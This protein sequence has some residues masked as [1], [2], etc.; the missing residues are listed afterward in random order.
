MNLIIIYLL[1]CYAIMAI[2]IAS[3][4]GKD[5]QRLSNRR[6]WTIEY[7]NRIMLMLSPIIIT[8]IFVEVWA[9][10]NSFFIEDFNSY[11]TPKMIATYIQNSTEKRGLR[12]RFYGKLYGR[13]RQNIRRG[14]CYLP[15]KK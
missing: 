14:Y 2:Y 15:R 6:N 12:K 9:C 3:T 10:I 13:E 4:N 7:V 5:A 1:S 11:N 8:Y